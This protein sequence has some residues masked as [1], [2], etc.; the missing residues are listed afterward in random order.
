MP[1]P[2]GIN[3]L[4]SV[5]IDTPPPVPHVVGSL[6]ST[7]WHLVASQCVLSFF[8]VENTDSVTVY[9][10]VYDCGELVQTY[11]IPQIGRAHV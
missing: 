3:H 11:P 5:S 2:Y 6:S 4:G 7:P 1:L 10:H 9:L 8:S